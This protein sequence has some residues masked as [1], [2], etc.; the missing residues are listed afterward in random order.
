MRQSQT[1]RRQGFGLRVQ[2]VL[3]LA[4]VILV[5]YVPL[6]FA[7]AQVTRATSLAYREES[8]RALG[9][10]VAA[11]VADV[12]RGTPEPKAIRATLESHVGE[13]G[14]LAVAVIGGD[15]ALLASAGTNRE[16]DALKLPRPPFGEAASR[17]TTS[18]GARALDVVLP[19]GEGAVLVRVRTDEDSA[20][21]RE[22]VRGIALYMGVFALAL[23]LIAYVALT[24]AIVRPIEQLARA[25]DRVA[26][27]SRTLDVPTTGAREIADLG[28]S[29]RSMHSRLMA[30]EKSLRDK[31]EELSTTKA[32]LGTTR[33]Q[34][35]GSERMAS[36]GKL[37]AG[38]AHEIGNPIAAI[39]GMHDLIEDGDLPDEDRADF[40][41]RMR[42]ETERINVVVRDLLDY[43]RPENGPPSGGVAVADVGEIVSD[44][45]A[46]VRPQKDW[47]SVETVVEIDDDLRVLISPQRLTQVILNLLL[48]A[49]A[50]MASMPTD[51]PR[52]I[53]VRAKKVTVSGANRGRIEVEDTGPGVPDAVR[54]RV[55]DPFVT[56]KE[57][58][59]GT[60]LG[61]SVCR[62]IVEGASGKIAVDATYT[63]GA[64]FVV[65]L[66]RVA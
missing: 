38:V 2:I 18:A 60:G 30:D 21:T 16:I 42:K 22:V 4:G 27:G 25:A 34:L 56:T 46:L 35:A 41:R 29:V 14:A 66:P 19:S 33:D 44:A 62:G 31:V 61:L 47:K 8:A 48:N 5:A 43:A 10:A 55:F 32:H 37:A 6:F 50:A 57:V 39:M 45:L 53:V 23:L 20:R 36:V 9:R 51:K 65:E 11:H 49:A 1:A 7:I 40:L 59:Q 54:D 24:R 15:G 12:S 13:G 3:A 58:G 26:N 17:V 28:A 63:G 52:K 64:R